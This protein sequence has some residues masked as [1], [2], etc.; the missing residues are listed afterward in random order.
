MQSTVQ[1]VFPLGT[2]GTVEYH[3]FHSVAAVLHTF[4]KSVNLSTMNF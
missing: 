1:T 3:H 2:K 4:M